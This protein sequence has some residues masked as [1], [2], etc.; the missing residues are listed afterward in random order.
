VNKSGSKYTRDYRA[1]GFGGGGGGG[2]G[3]GPGNTGPRP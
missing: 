3:N 2:G 1:G